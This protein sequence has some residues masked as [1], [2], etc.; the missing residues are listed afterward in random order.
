MTASIATAVLQDSADDLILG[1]FLFLLA[2]CALLLCYVIA[3]LLKQGIWGGILALGT[4]Y[5]LI[6]VHTLAQLYTIPSGMERYVPFTAWAAL[7][8]LC[9]LMLVLA[10][11]FVPWAIRRWFHSRRARPRL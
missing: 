3:A 10:A 2:V 6:M 8:L 5:G 7:L 9:D 4:G 11:G 1:V